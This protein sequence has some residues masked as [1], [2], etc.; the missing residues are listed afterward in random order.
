MFGSSR[1]S[2]WVQS[3]REKCACMHVYTY[4]ERERVFRVSSSGI[5]RMVVGRYFLFW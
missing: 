5:L 3:T 4:I 2:S 1:G